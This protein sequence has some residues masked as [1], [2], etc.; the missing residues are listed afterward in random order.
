VLEHLL[1]TIVFDRLGGK[2][3]DN[4][5]TRSTGPRATTE[6]N[7]SGGGGLRAR[8]VWSSQKADHKDVYVL[9][10]QCHSFFSR[11]SARA[12]TGSSA[13]VARPPFN[14]RTYF[15]TANSFLGNNLCIFT[16]A[17]SE[18]RLGQLLSIR[19]VYSSARI[20]SRTL[21][22]DFDQGGPNG[23]HRGI[24][25]K[26]GLAEAQSKA[27]KEVLEQIANASAHN[28]AKTKE[29]TN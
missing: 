22:W 3:F 20:R 9:L 15:D 16:V 4:G 28:L 17:F 14:V 25:N 1:V 8:D 23:Y 5:A 2:G 21:P 7:I 12:R 27:P 13:S 29:Q 18:S 24:L 6:R 19:L 11:I 10:T 26:H